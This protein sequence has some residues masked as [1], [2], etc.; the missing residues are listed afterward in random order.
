V[1]QGT[2]TEHREAAEESLDR[3]MKHLRRAQE[4][5]GRRRCHEAGVEFAK[6]LSCA[7]E[8]WSEMP[9]AESTRITSRAVSIREAVKKGYM[10]F[11]DGCVGED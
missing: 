1:I 3:A 11:L 9:W 2:K 7:A 8:G 6:A 10:G 4:L 5:Q